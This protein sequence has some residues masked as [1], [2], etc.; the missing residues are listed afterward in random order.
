MVKLGAV[1]VGEAAVVAVLE[2]DV[3]VLAGAEPGLPR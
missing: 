1:L 2:V 3:L